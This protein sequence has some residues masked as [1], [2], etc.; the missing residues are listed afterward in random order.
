MKNLD[1]RDEPEFVV[2]WVKAE[3]GPAGA[4]EAFEKLESRLPTLKG[5]K[6]Y[7]IFFRDPGNYYAAVRLNEAQI[8]DM[9]LERGVI[10]A[11]L[12]A[13]TKLEDWFGNEYRISW[14]FKSLDDLCRKKGYVPDDTRPD[15]EFY[16]SNKEVI[17]MVPIRR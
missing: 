2:A 10:P 4:K 16:R 6:M 5:R 11:G 14:A 1:I 7:G 8:D 9:G 17:V 3:S 15:I 13:R 12:Y